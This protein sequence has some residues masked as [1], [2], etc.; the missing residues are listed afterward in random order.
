MNEDSQEV[1][2]KSD[3]GTTIWS[4]FGLVMVLI[5]VGLL[6]GVMVFI[7]PRFAEVFADFGE[8]LP[9]I[10][11]I[12]LAIS[13]FLCTWWFV[14]IPLVGLV[15]AGLV[16]LY[17]QLP[18]YRKLLASIYVVVGWIL[19]AIGVIG[20]VFAIFMPLITLMTAMSER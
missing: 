5:A 16:A 1:K 12:V 13:H 3:V 9:V 11:K 20:V 14:V 15:V 7:V 19:F 4:V 18:R 10:T 2:T 6:L 17:V 8:D